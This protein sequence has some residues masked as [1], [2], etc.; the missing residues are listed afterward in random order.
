[1]FGFIDITRSR[2]IPVDDAAAERLRDRDLQSGLP[3]H[4]GGSDYPPSW[5]LFVSGMGRIGFFSG[6]Q[7]KN[8]DI[9]HYSRS[10]EIP[11]W[12]L[13]IVVSIP[14]QIAVVRF[15]RR[16]RRT[17]K[18]YCAK[19]GYDLRATPDRCPECGTIPPK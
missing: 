5:A 1:M 17:V 15:V 12:L 8:T 16:S 2:L 3:W 10:V 6:R 19:C 7:S 13:L 11:D 14:A 9:P 18:G 4:Y